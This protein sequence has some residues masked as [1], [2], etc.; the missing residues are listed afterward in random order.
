M[1]PFC[2]TAKKVSRSRSLSRRLMRGSNPMKSPNKDILNAHPEIKLLFICRRR[3]LQILAGW[4]AIDGSAVMRPLWPTFTISMLSVL[5]VAPLAGPSA[6]AESFPSKP[7][8]IILQ[9]AA[10]TAPDVLGRMIAERLSQAWGQQVLIVNR[11]GAGGLLAAQAAVAAE[12]D[13]YTL[14]QATTAGLIVLPV[15]QKLTF[16]VRRDF[17]PIGLMGEQPFFIAVAPSLGVNALPELIALAKKRPGEI[18]YVAGS[19]GGMP[20]LTA[21]L[22]RSEAG[23][24]LTFV[25]YPSIPQSLQEVI[26]G[27]IPMIVEAMPGL[28]GAIEGGSIKPLAV[29]SAKRLPNFPDVPTVGA[30]IPGFS[31]TGWF[32]LMAPAKT[33]DEIVLKVSQSVRAVINRPELQQKFETLGAFLRATSPAE[34]AEFIRD[35]QNSWWPIVKKTLPTQ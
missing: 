34:T 24:D 6:H 33:P 31:V 30:F 5:A 21:E 20:H 14:Y 10:G 9:A 15:T 29:T 22:F 19:R 11:P 23:I 18:L 25:P 35:Q 32:A 26:A 3:T 28:S 2:A 16:D 17:V 4:F 1:L 8:K 12:P 13:G 27:R 7:V